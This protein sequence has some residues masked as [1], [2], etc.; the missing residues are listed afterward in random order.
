MRRRPPPPRCAG[1][2]RPPASP[3]KGAEEAPHRMSSSPFLE[4]VLVDVIV[5]ELGG[6]AAARQVA[7]A[8][9]AADVAAR[10]LQRLADVLLLEQRR[11]FLQL[12]VQAPVQ[13]DP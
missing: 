3:L 13:V 5:G 7:D 1:A 2:S 8:G 11:Q 10:S 4:L 6:E 9:A 12:L